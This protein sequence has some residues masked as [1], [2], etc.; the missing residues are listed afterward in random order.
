MKITWISPYQYLECWRSVS[1]I[2]LHLLKT[3][4]LVACE[5]LR[6]RKSDG[7]DFFKVWSLYWA[8]F[9]IR[10]WY[11]TCIFVEKLYLKAKKV[12]FYVKLLGIILKD[13][14]SV[15]KVCIENIGGTKGS[16]KLYFPLFS[17]IIIIY[18]IIMAQQ[19]P[20]M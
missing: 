7:Q 14:K 20:S 11:W 9:V 17:E 15:L 13:L 18:F 5:R 1:F 16:N 19:G 2:Y 12:L 3:G 6:E 4:L 10:T 8:V